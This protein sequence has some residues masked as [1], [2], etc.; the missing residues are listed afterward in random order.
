[1]ETIQRSLVE[2]IKSRLTV[3]PKVVFQFEFSVLK[4]SKINV[5]I[6]DRNIRQPLSFYLMLRKVE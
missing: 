4:T 3:K 1:M 2:S 5:T 6:V